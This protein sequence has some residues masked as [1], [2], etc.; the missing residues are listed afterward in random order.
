MD[1]A[2]SEHYGGKKTR[3]LKRKKIIVG[4]GVKVGCTNNN[5]MKHTE[6]GELPFDN[7]SD[8]AQDVQIFDDMYSPL[9]SGGKF[10]KNGCQLFYDQPN[11]HVL[12]GE[13]RTKIK[14]YYRRSQK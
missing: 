7:I 8:R 11:V 12:C 4:T 10:V 2:A 14:K 5:T 3:V 6:K 13:T 1:S 9:L